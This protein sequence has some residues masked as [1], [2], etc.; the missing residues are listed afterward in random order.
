M[1]LGSSQ[2]DGSYTA[3]ATSVYYTSWTL[4]TDSVNL[5]QTRSATQSGIVGVDGAVIAA[6]LANSCFATGGE[7][8][9]WP[10]DGTLAV[11]TPLEAVLQVQALTPV[12]VKNAA[13]GW[14][15]VADGISGGTI[16][17]ISTAS[18]QV[19]ATMGTVPVGKA[20]YLQADFGSAQH[21]GFVQASNALSTQNA[22]TLDEYLLNTGFSYSLERVTTNL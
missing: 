20:V 22:A 12:T 10:T 19:I 18:N 5:V 15:Y 9:P 4:T 1:L 3:T 21:T 7:A 2:N 16:S 6:P 8:V 17:A 14:T 11:R 13:T